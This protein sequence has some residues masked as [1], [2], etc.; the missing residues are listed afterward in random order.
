MEVRSKTEA[1]AEGG[2]SVVRP[3][4]T[5]GWGRGFAG[6][7]LMAWSLDVVSSEASRD[8]FVISVVERQ[9]FT[10]RDGMGI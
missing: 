3:T 9:P 8:V 2:S 7:W 1:G 4:P 6:G 10:F 5:S